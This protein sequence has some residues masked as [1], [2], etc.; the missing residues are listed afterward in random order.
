LTMAQATKERGQSS[1]N[2]KEN[3]A[4]WTFK[5]NAAAPE[6]VPRSH[7]PVQVPMPGYFYP[8]CQYA[9]GTSGNWIYVADQESA[10]RSPSAAVHSHH[11]NHHANENY[12]TDEMKQKII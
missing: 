11:Q 6:F 7:S 2:T 12:I 10:V 1:E 9:D 3:A 8:F 5:F 4:E